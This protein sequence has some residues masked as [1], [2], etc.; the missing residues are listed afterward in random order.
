MADFLI[1]AFQTADTP[2]ITLASL[3]DGAY[4]ISAAV[5]NTS[6]KYPR[7]VLEL[8]LPSAVTCGAGAPFVGIQASFAL[9]GTNYPNPGN[10]ATASGLP[11]VASI[12]A[13][14]GA[15]FTRGVTQAFDLLPCPFKLIMFNS[16]GVALPSG[17]FGFKLYRFTDLAG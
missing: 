7:A 6:G 16:L 9:D 2:S 8:V 10:A 14:A 5:D 1:G 3:A 13:P 4:A 17:M 15:A 12:S 11:Q